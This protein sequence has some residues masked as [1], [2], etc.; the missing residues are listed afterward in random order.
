MPLLLQWGH[1]D[2]AVEEAE[3]SGPSA[4]DIALQW[5]HGDE[6]VEEVQYQKA[7]RGRD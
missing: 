2:E 5:G 7:I 3:S 6:A 4:L 1:G